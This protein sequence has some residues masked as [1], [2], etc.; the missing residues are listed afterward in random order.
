M[1]L[2]HKVGGDGGHARRALQLAVIEL[3]LLL[4]QLHQRQSCFGIARPSA[5]SWTAVCSVWS[6]PRLTIKLVTTATINRKANN[7]APIFDAYIADLNMLANFLFNG[8]Q[9]NAHGMQ[10]SLCAAGYI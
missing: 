8:Y 6:N 10:R 2:L 7:P 3:G 9:S 5:L 4:G 1:R